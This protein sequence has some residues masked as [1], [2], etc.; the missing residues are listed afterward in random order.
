MPRVEALLIVRRE[1]GI[2]REFQTE[3][4]GNFIVEE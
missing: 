4:F 1:A 3:G 2:Y